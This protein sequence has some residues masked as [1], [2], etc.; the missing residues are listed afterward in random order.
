M[1]SLVVGVSIGKCVYIRDIRPPTQWLKTL[2]KHF[3][4]FT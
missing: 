4:L 1:S 3:L 2:L